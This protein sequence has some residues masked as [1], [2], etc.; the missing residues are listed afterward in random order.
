MTMLLKFSKSAGL[1]LIFLSNSFTISYGS[2]NAHKR[3][4][5][6]VILLDPST[7][8]ADIQQQNG[9]GFLF[10]SS[11]TALSRK[12]LKKNKSSYNR[13]MKEGEWIQVGL[14]LFGEASLDESGCSVDISSDGK[15]III[16]APSNDG[17]GTDSGHARVYE[18]KEGIWIPVGDD[19]DGE[20]AGD[21]SGKAVGISSNGMRVIIGAPLNN[22]N[23]SFWTGHARVYEDVNGKWTQVGT[24]IDGEGLGDRSGNVDINSDG[25]RVVLGSA[26]NDGN[27]ISSGHARIFDEI[28]GKWT[29]VG[30]DIDGDKIGDLSGWSVAISADGTRV[31]IGG[32]FWSHGRVRVYEEKNGEWI[33]VGVDIDGE[34]VGDWSGDSVG[35]S[36]NGTRV[37][38]GAWANDGS[39]PSSGHARVFQED[40]NGTW[41][42][43][44]SDIDGE[45]AGDRSGKSVGISSDGKRVIIGAPFNHGRSADSG[46]ARI[47]QEVNGVWTQIGDDI[48]GLNPSDM[49][50]TSVGINLDGNRVIIGAP[51]YD[52]NGIS[53]GHSRVFELS[54]RPIPHSSANKFSISLVIVI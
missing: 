15:R 6:G 35:I 47:Y 39:G 9:T 19:I 5:K 18:E 8:Q 21:I 54:F 37:I 45:A 48:N 32:P 4:S 26:S 17:N 2:L 38:I 28:N 40:K 1:A 44:G 34:S 14:D 42:Q 10:P 16:G 23:G 51:G 11:D 12:G 27:G 49:A 33:Q 43:V 30:K 52:M 29:Q 50:G 20:I 53:S 41:F 13:I 3:V 36:F 24:D 25:T 31:I 46:H 7:Q 22:G